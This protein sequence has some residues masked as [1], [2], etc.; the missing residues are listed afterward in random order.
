LE[1]QLGKAA[2]VLTKEKK[3]NEEMLL[4]YHRLKKLMSCLMG[5]LRAILYIGFGSRI[6]TL[7]APALGPWGFALQYMGPVA[8][9]GIGYIL[10]LS[11]F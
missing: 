2:E 10:A 5:A 3:R 1:E 4:R 9:Y 11:I 6:F 8:A 7:L